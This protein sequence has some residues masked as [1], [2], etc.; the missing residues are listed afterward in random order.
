MGKMSELDI[1]VQQYEAEFKS[2][3]I[4][5]ISVV[6]ALQASGLSEMDGWQLLD[7]WVMEKEGENTEAG[8]GA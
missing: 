8:K 1:D 3:V 6:Q 2:G 4:G 5:P 7:K